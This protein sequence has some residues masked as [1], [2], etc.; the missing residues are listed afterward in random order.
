MI[1][2]DLGISA[3]GFAERPGFQ[4]MLAQVTKQEVGIILCVDA[5]R[6]SRNSKDWAHLFE[7]CGFF[8]TLVADL[9]QVYDLSHPNDRLVLG[10]KG[11]IS[12][13]ELRMLH[14]RLQGALKAKAAR[15][16]LRM[17]IPVGYVYDHAGRIIFDPD[18]R[19]QS[20]L[21]L[22]FDQ[23]DR[24]T[25]VRQLAIW[26][27]DTKT[28]FPARKINK[29]AAMSWEIP[30]ANG[31]NRLLL[32]PIYTG[33]FVYGRRV[34]RVEYIEGNLRKRLSSPL[35]VDQCQVCIREHHPA[36]ITWERW[37]ANVAR[38]KE[39]RAR[40]TMQENRGAIRAGLALLSGICRCG[41]CGG[42][43]SVQYKQTSALYLCDGE[44][45]R[46][47]EP[48][49]SFGSKLI[50]QAVSR[51]LS[52]ALQPLSIEAAI[53]ASDQNEKE[54]V[55][56]M[57][58][59]QFRVEAAQYEA[60]RAFEQFNLV[61]PKN[62]L[63]AGTLESRLNDRLAELHQAKERLEGLAKA[64][65]TL[66]EEQKKTLHQLAKDFQQVWDHP[67]ASPLLKKRLLR[68]AIHEVIVTH[69]R[70]EQ[71]LEV[72]IHWQGG[73]HTRLSVN[74]RATPIGRKADPDLV[75]TV[76]ELAKTLADGEIARILNMKSV[77]TPTGMRW[78]KDR[79]KEF[80]YHHH[81]RSTASSSRGE[82]SKGETLSLREAAQYLGISY[83]GLLALER[84]GLIS[85]NQV[86]DFAPCRISRQELDSEEVQRMVK[87]MKKTGRLPTGGCAKGQLTLFDEN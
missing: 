39:N 55:Q 45:T 32:H 5:S 21:A 28:L 41:H 19:I 23:F 61:D 38:I 69:H 74:K 1:Q 20:A 18:Q 59:A 24:T 22:M 17:N 16:E 43:L 62:R 87:V 79:V 60:D 49:L 48:C 73:V 35:P 33:A 66:T 86:T 4:G 15:G 65:K 72:T 53:L 31:L 78:T 40:W 80:R 29:N 82:A 76:A 14:N 84:R 30:G 70:E 52:R 44:H 11:T 71:R 36:Y 63:V 46:G 9:D 58:S 37:V 57:E 26:Y 6:L 42:K 34:K 81:L 77:E 67:Q 75:A 83:R 25:S 54:K 8:G 85:K 10:I 50:D 7:L 12:E 3:S 27:R 56:E 68:T 2:D 47:A 13:V 64:K 51:E